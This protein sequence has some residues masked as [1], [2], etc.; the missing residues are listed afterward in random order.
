[1]NL[2]QLA[3]HIYLSSVYAAL[4]FAQ[5]IDRGNNKERNVLRLKMLIKVDMVTFIRV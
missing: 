3:V 2:M 4:A 1:M 5:F